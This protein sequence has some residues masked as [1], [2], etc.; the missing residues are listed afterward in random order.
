MDLG[1]V[2]RAAREEAG[3]T[4]A[5]LARRAGASANALSRWECGT[6]PVRSD[7][8]DRVLEACG[9][10]VRFSLVLRHTD[11]DELLRQLA[12]LPA[13]ER[14]DRLPW[15]L[16]TAVLQELQATGHVRFDGCWAAAALG[17]P[18]LQRVGG[19]LLSTDPQEQASVVA[20]LR[21]WAPGQLEGRMTYGVSWDDKVFERNPHGL[22]ST[23]LL[24]QFRIDVADEGGERRVRV[25]DQAWR[26]VDPDSLVPEHVDVMVLERCR[27]AT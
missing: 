7:D 26:V 2:L 15:M 16:G 25:G 21:P 22:W 4:Q 8:V 10:D 20:V 19:I 1:A 17:L 12:A 23:P 27:R 11:T 5:E 18:H 24:G 13:L 14:V 6:R 3:L 9:R